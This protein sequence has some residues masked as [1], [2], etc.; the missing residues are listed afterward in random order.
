[1]E[2]NI[3]KP[4]Y[5]AVLPANVRY[6][7]I[8]ASA[9]LIYAEITALCNK[10]GYCWATNKY[11]AGLYE[12]NQSTVSRLISKLAKKEFLIVDI[13]TS[14]KGQEVLRILRIP[15]AKNV[16]TPLLKKSK[17]NT[18]SINIKTNIVPNGTVE[19]VQQVY[20]L[21]IEKFGKNS[22]TYKLTDKR[23]AKLKQRLRD[24]GEDVLIQA[25]NNTAESGFHR[26]DNDRGWEAD[27]D[28]IVRSYEQVERLANDNKFKQ[29][30][31]AEEMEK[32]V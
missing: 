22:S 15:H 2:P 14:S 18:T 12:I 26:G 16:N 25:I 29:G 3:E 20:D 23:K 11:F 30:F 10:E 8:P 6:A 32:Y 27:L 13:T 9:K 5:Y 7:D 31:S 4:N 19:Q 21:F 17:D 28:F 1:M 24:A